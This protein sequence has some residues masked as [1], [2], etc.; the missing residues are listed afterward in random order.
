MTTTLFD[1][2]K[3]FNSEA[4]EIALQ[5]ED[6]VTTSPASIKTYATT[7][8]ECIVDDMLLKS[9]NDNINPLANFTPK[10]KKLSMFGIIKYS[11]ETQLINAYKLRNTA[12]YAL[13]KTADEDRRLALELYEKLF[14]IAWR[15]FDEFGGNE[16]NYLGKPKFIPPFRENEDKQLVE[17]PNIERMEKIFD[18]CIICGRK[19]NSHYHNLCSTCNNKIE[20]VEDIINLKNHF[21]SKFSKRNVI[22]LGYSKP[23]SDVLIRELLNENLI[24][25]TDKTYSFNDDL[26]DEYLDEIKMYGEIEVVLSE[27]ASGKLSLRDIKSSDYY[28][29]GKNSVKPYIQLYNIVSDAI[30][31]EF[32]SQLDLDIPVCEIMDDT[33]ITNEEILAWYHHQLDLTEKGIKTKDFIKY[34]KISIDSYIKLRSQG[35]TKNEIIDELHLPDDIVDFWMN[36]YIIELDYFKKSL[37]DTLIDLILKSIHENKTKEEILTNLEISQDDFKRLLDENSEFSKIYKRD[38]TN[39]RRDDFLYYLNRNNFLNSLKKANLSEN[40][41]QEW[42]TSGEKDFELGHETEL[43]KFYTDTTERQ[44]NLYLNYRKNA[45]TKEEACIKINKDPKT[46]DQWLKR[47]DNDIF[48]DFQKQYDNITYEMIINGFKKGMTFKEVSKLSDI[49]ANKLKKYIQKGEKGDEKYAELYEVYKNTYV[50]NQLNIFLNEI[51]KS[52]LKKALKTS[53]L[54]EDELNKYYIEGLSGNEKFKDFSDEY[55]QIKLNNYTKEIINKGK[56]S[57]KAARNSNFIK[58]DFE[59]K[60][61]EIDDVLIKK[62]LDIVIPLIAEGFHLKYV[63]GKINVDVEVLFDWYVKGYEG[64]ETFKEFSEYCWDCKLES[65]IDQTQKIFD[66]GISE[67][68]FLKYILNKNA[69]PEYKFLK[70]HNLFDINKENKLLSDEEQFSIYINEVV[71]DEFIFNDVLELLEDESESVESIDEIIDAIDDEEIKEHMKKQVNKG[72]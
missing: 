35:K 16:Y 11:F 52:K 50:L 8:L 61:K 54:S 25:K 5:I 31:N 24:L 72:D 44:I 4:Y 34:N 66:K 39:K 56:S 42:L 71:G 26:F 57:S 10:V 59:Y 43:S 58:E 36:T 20:Q 47:D 70:K 28:L 45:I 7:F 63:A 46:I 17:V 2:L 32:L 1:F 40:E 12:H 13:K 18:H 67:K 30:F 41:I 62:Q 19:N 60:Q 21:E 64:D 6:E 23:Y 48:T 33:T 3:N 27:F 37:D 69:L 22:D 15:Y 49:S 55:F 38:Y 68:F 53:N 65:V 29:K 9:G 51:K 14:H